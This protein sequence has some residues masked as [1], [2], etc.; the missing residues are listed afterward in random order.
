MAGKGRQLLLV[1]DLESF[2]FDP[3]R[4]VAI[5]GKPCIAL[6]TLVIAVCASAPPGE[7]IPS[8]RPIAQEW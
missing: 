3:D 6:G 4:L 2:G 5:L 8:A 7:T 1:A